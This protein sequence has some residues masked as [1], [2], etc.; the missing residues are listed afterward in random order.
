MDD[1]ELPRLAEAKTVQWL[2]DFIAKIW[3]NIDS[4]AKKIVR[5][6]V[7]PAIQ[8]AMP[9]V[10]KGIHFKNFTL[11]TKPLI[12][13]PVKVLDLGKEG[14]DFRIGIDLQSD[15]DIEVKLSVADVGI[16]KLR[17]IGELTLKFCSLLNEVPVVGGVAMYFIDPPQI[18]FEFTG[19]GSLL[20]MQGLAGQI[21][22]IVDAQ[23]KDM[24]VLPNQITTCIGKEEQGADLATMKCP[25]PMALL[26]VHAMSARGIRGAD[27]HMFG[28][29]TSDAYCK[30]SL[31]DE[32]YTSQVVKNT[33]EPRWKEDDHGYMLL[34][35]GAQRLTLS[36]WDEDFGNADDSIGYAT[37]FKAA[38]ALRDRHI[39]YPGIPLY[40]KQSEPG[41]QEECGRVSLGIDYFAIDYESGGIGEHDM[42]L[43]EVKL[44]KAIM[45]P[46]SCDKVKVMATF[47][48]GDTKVCKSTPVGSAPKEVSKGVDE[49]LSGMIKRSSEKGFDVKK[50]AELLALKED[51]V[52]GVIDGDKISR[53]KSQKLQ[54]PQVVDIEA[55]LYFP[56]ERRLV[57]DNA[58]VELVVA[59]SKGH[60]IAS[61]TVGISRLIQ[62]MR[63]GLSCRDT[64]DMPSENCK[65]KHGDVPLDVEIKVHPTKPVSRL[66]RLVDAPPDWK[67]A[68]EAYFGASMVIPEVADFFDEEWQQNLGGWAI[69]QSSGGQNEGFAEHHFKGKAAVLKIEQ[70]VQ[71]AV[72]RLNTE[73][74]HKA[75][76]EGYCIVYSASKQLYFLLFRKEKDRLTHRLFPDCFI[77]S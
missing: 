6:K 56:V 44:D 59:D 15:T 67:A 26:K 76:P 47:R 25:R 64:T 57:N 70:S 7:E 58:Q 48:N 1:S 27:W 17:M 2:N 62:A 66:C 32:T 31:S 46:N 69:G 22:K 60:A 37:P 24:L 18:S 50:I 53:S 20:N 63:D 29:A 39:I 77:V 11:G 36:V 72:D 9:S 14:F 21:R 55:T 19:L 71:K 38:V 74:G 4:A 40:P 41:T 68:R 73:E 13:G 5:D 30:V 51:V 3:P 34:Y 28:K 49:A 23:V 43:L 8:E 16:K 45:P 12:L 10:A 54:T 33:C 65:G 42:C 35:D 61:K 75:C 52:Q